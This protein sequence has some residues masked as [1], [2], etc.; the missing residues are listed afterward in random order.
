M[1]WIGHVQGR[2]MTALVRS[3]VMQ[4]EGSKRTKGRPNRTWVTVVRKDLRAYDL[5][6]DMPLDRVESQSMIRI[7]DP[8]VVW[9]RLC[10]LYS[11]I[12]VL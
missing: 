5:K 2:P 1:R 3:Y 12:Q 11:W 7:A 4:I 9:I 6:E 10:H 8:Q